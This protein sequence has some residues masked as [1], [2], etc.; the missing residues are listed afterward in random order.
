MKSFQRQNLTRKIIFSWPA[1][2]LLIV[3]FAFIGRWTFQNYLRFSA[4][5]EA[6]L[7][8]KKDRE[9]LD[10]KKNDLESRLSYLSNPYGLEKELRRRFS[11]KKPDEEMAIIVDR[12]VP[13]PENRA[14]SSESLWQRFI[15]FFK[16]F[17]N[18]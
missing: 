13:G 12:K 16:S 4:A 7:R 1:I 15:T 17:F 10:R 11:L 8:V 3:L 2:I 6:Y 18:F 5:K 14:G 9:E